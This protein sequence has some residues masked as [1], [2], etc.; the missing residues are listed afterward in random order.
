MCKHTVFF[1]K[2]EFF[3]YISQINVSLFWILLDNY[4][5]IY[6]NKRRFVTYSSPVF[7]FGDPVASVGRLAF[8]FTD[9]RNSSLRSSDTTGRSF[10]KSKTTLDRAPMVANPDHRRLT[11]SLNCRPILIW[12]IAFFLEIIRM[13][14]IPIA[15]NFC[16]YFLCRLALP[17][18]AGFY[19]G[20]PLERERGSG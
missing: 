8:S 16:L 4:I 18:D 11:L 17:W 1:W 10:R 14:W 6:T 9:R 20:R 15:V 5:H 13:V 19:A 2:N 7:V 3:L 12:E